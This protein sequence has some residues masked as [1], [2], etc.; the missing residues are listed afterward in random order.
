[1]KNSNWPTS[2]KKKKNK[3]QRQRAQKGGKYDIQ[4]WISKLGIE[5]PPFSLSKKKHQYLGSGTH[6]KKK[7]S[8]V[9]IQE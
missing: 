6:L 2:K 5:F 3:R 8:V 7:N 4:S 9:G 1:M